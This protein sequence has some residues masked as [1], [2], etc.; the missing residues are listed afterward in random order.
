MVEMIK[1]ALIVDGSFFNFLDVN[2]ERL[3]A[4]D[5]DLLEEAIFVSCR[6]KRD[7]VQEDETEKGKRRLLNFG[8]TIGHAIEC[9][10]DFSLEHGEAVA[11]GLI[12]EGYI[13]HKLGYLPAA[14]FEKIKQILL[15][16]ALPLHLP[17][18]FSSEAMIK[19]M[20]MDKKTLLGIPRFVILD[21][22]GSALPCDTEYCMPIPEELLI[23]ALTWMNDDLCGN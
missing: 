1:H 16:Y 8:H 3:L 23:D 10:M 18:R 7:I 17:K 12:V 14:Q 9:L 13:A 21:G 2:S 22:I 4:R 6:I 20:A 11:I 19:V 5:L 15:K